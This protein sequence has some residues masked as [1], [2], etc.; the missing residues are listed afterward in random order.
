MVGPEGA[1]AETRAV[2]DREVGGRAHACAGEDAGGALLAPDVGG[3]G[4]QEVHCFAVFG[5][6]EAGFVRE[7]VLDEV[8]GV[9]DGCFGVVPGVG[10]GDGLDGDGLKGVG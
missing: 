8:H 2:E 1:L 6:A 10:V 5:P 9:A 7:G 4:L 3:V